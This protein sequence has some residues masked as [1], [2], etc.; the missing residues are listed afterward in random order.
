MSQVAGTLIKP[1]YLGMYTLDSVKVLTYDYIKNKYGN[2]L[3]TSLT[4]IV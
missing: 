3:K 4:L 2:K 1:A